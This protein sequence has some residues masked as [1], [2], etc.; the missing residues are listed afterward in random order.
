MKQKKM[1]NTLTFF[2]Q[3]ENTNFNESIINLITLWVAHRVVLAALL[4]VKIML[5]VLL[6]ARKS[7]LL[8]T[9]SKIMGFVVKLKI[10]DRPVAD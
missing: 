5:I 6:W 10:I 8:S 7:I 2:S 1:K 9:L 3:N 4:T